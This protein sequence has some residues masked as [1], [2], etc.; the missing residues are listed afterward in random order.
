MHRLSVITLAIHLNLFFHVRGADCHQKAQQQIPLRWVY[1]Q[2]ADVSITNDK[3]EKAGEVEKW[4]SVNNKRCGELTTH[5]NCTYVLREWQLDLE[6][7]KITQDTC[8][9]SNS[10]W[11]FCS[12]EILMRYI[13][14]I[15]LSF[16]ST[17]IMP[18]EYPFWHSVQIC[19]LL[20]SVTYKWDKRQLSSCGLRTHCLVMLASEL[21]TFWSTAQSLY[22]WVTSFCN[23][24]CKPWLYVLA[25]VMHVLF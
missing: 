19:C 23:P 8:L 11:M 4:R 6:L 21:A 22:L 10:Q 25:E 12:S 3:L 13:W 16:P 17:C 24:D 15:S 14:L 2:Q 9:Y 18:C 5:C 7:K 1:C 20:S